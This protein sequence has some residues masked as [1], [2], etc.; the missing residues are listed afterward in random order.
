MYDNNL[1]LK[2]Y[3]RVISFFILMLFVFPSSE[4]Y[5]S[6]YPI[7]ISPGSSSPGCEE[8]NV[9]YS[10]YSMTINQG[11]TIVWTNI[12]SAAHT[13]TSASPSEIFDSSLI[14]S[15]SSFEHTFDAS[16]NYPYYC[17]VHPWMIGEIV[18]ASLEYYDDVSPVGDTDK[19]GIY[20]NSDKCIKDPETYNNYQDSDGC[21]DDPTLIYVGTV[22]GIA[23]AGTVIG[24]KLHGRRPD[25]PK[26]HVE[27]RIT[28][29]IEK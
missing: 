1:I 11:D 4:I 26:H 3:I 7:E 21:P 23:A 16:G 13:V 5:A 22:I 15:D 18:V 29:G 8:K 25:P 17:M 9:C 19:D 12:D 24:I 6:T 20:D 10:P 14:M 2:Y 27:V 28:G